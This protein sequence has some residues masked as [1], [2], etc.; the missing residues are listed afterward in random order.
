MEEGKKGLQTQGS[1]PEPQANRLE[2]HTSLPL[3]QW[4]DW[5]KEIIIRLV[6][7]DIYLSKLP[8]SKNVVVFLPDPLNCH[9]GSKETVSYPQ[10]GKNYNKNNN[11][12]KAC[13]HRCR[14]AI[15]YT[16][17]ITAIL[18]SSHSWVIAIERGAMQYEPKKSK[19]H[20]EGKHP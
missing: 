12:C 1:N 10:N 15:Q 4:H 11:Q 6:F 18:A 20:K 8:L 13:F 2:T 19:Q 14:K 9:R 7:L 16:P 17:P 5:P 3:N